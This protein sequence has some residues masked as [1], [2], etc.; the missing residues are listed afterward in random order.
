MGELRKDDPVTPELMRKHA[1]V[2]LDAGFFGMCKGM[3]PA[4]LKAIRTA[5]FEPKAHKAYLSFSDYTWYLNLAASIEEDVA[6][7]VAL[8]DDLRAM[9]GLD[10]EVV[11][12]VRVRWLDLAFVYFTILS[13]ER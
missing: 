3:S 9:D 1:E 5:T 7:G 13:N 2:A 8:D 10:K 6:E 4:L 11:D 12:R